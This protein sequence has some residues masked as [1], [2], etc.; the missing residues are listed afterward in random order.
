M[1]NYTRSTVRY[2]SNS[3][4]HPSAQTSSQETTLEIDFYNGFRH[5]IH[6]PII[7]LH[8]VCITTVQLNGFFEVVYIINGNL[9]APSCGYAENVR[10]S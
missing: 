8:A 2:L 6:P 7:A 4:P 5:Q 1:I 3:A 9:L 10:Y